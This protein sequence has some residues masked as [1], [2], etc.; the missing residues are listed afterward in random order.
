MYS[1][2]LNTYI[3]AYVNM[4]LSAREAINHFRLRLI[5]DVPLDDAI[6]Y[7]QVKSAG[8]F[9]HNTGASITSKQTNADK[10]TY[11]L[12]HVIERSPDLYLPMLLEVMKKSGAVNLINLADDIKAATSGVYICIYICA[13]LCNV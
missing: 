11:F 10:V 5:Q 1:R 8:L 4:P 6:F 7:A 3:R 12:Q 2:Q 9:I 13:C